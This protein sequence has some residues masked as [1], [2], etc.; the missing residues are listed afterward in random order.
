MYG[1]GNTTCRFDIEYP[2]VS[3]HY[4]FWLA[5]GATCEEDQGARVKQ[6]LAHVLQLACLSVDGVQLVVRLVWGH[7]IDDV[8]GYEVA[9][10]PVLDPRGMPLLHEQLHTRPQLASAQT[11]M[12]ASVIAVLQARL[13]TV[14]AQADTC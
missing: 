10:T 14:T 13:Q 1:C 6:A 5:G 7:G 11:V 9:R 2:P 3:M 8:H 12:L 4:S